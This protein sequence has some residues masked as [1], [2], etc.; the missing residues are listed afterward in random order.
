MLQSKL[1]L[2]VFGEAIRASVVHRR[3]LCDSFRTTKAFQRLRA[4]GFIRLI[5]SLNNARKSLKLVSWKLR[6]LVGLFQGITLLLLAIL[7]VAILASFLA[8]NKFEHM[9]INTGLVRAQIK[10]LAIVFDA[11]ATR[12]A[13]TRQSSFLTFLHFPHLPSFIFS[14]CFLYF[15][16]IRSNRFNNLDAFDGKS[17]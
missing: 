17:V 10:F 2:Q 6:T 12:F 13:K 15:F 5:Q 3:F 1:N 9:T 4:T 11:R 7:F 8:S 16:Q 14:A